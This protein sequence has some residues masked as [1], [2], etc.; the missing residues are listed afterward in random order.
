MERS[1]YVWHLHIRAVMLN[2]IEN[3]KSLILYLN[4]GWNHSGRIVTI[5]SSLKD[6]ITY[7]KD[8]IAMQ[9]N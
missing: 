6:L 2:P 9:F 5:Q 1:I 4:S 8:N 3:F 7:Y